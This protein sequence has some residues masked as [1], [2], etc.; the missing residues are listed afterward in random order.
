PSRAA[1]PSP[2]A[3][4]LRRHDECRVPRGVLLRCRDGAEIAIRATAIPLR[5]SDEEVTGALLVFRDA[6]QEHHY[7]T[8]LS[9]QASHDA[10]TG[11]INRREFERRLSLAL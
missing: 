1:A 8:Q 11:L 10:L 9:H 4:A 7:A 6:R 3:R 2:V 5:N